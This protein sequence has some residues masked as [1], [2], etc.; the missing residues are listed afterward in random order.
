MS[1]TIPTVLKE[2]VGRVGMESD[3]LCRVAVE[4]AERYIVLSLL[5]HILV[6]FHNKKKK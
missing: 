3:L 4:A 6:N 5:L 2:R 1:G